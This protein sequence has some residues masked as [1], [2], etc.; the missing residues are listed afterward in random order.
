MSLGSNTLQTNTLGHEMS[1]IPKQI[2][3]AIEKASDKSGVDFSYLVKQAKAESSF[4]P[5]A[6]AKTSSA[7]GLY[8]FI[9]STWIDMVNKYGDDYGMN[10]AGKS[11]SEILSMRK[12]PESASFMAAAFASENEKSLDNNWGGDVG[13]TELYFAH[14]LGASGAAAFLNARDE[15]PIRSA[16]DI[17]PRAARAN[18]NV[19]YDRATGQPRS[20]EAVYQFFNN[21]FAPD[22]A[23]TSNAKT[24]VAS[25]APTP[26]PIPQQKVESAAK[27]IHE[28]PYAN[29]IIAQRSR[30]MREAAAHQGGYGQLKTLE[31][32]NAPAKNTF[33]QR[34][35]LAQTSKTHAKTPFFSLLAQ[36]VDL[37]LLTQ[38]TTPSKVISDK[39]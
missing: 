4:N 9:D 19:F 12:D 37:M 27:T 39:S 16:A 11:R 29:N 31:L 22:G 18:R 26:P 23:Q 6:K 17:F 3:T 10:I 15:N 28:S 30:Q 5:N 36:P 1:Q 38:T 24:I 25:S 21:K 14:F 32:L 35:T 13:A 7:T 33:T 8:Q 2:L 34:A 20:L